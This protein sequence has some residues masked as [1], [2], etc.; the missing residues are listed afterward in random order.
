METL[1]P[2]I[3]GAIIFGAFTA[4]ALLR[5]PLERIVVGQAP[6]TD[7]PKRQIVLDV[8]L[9]FLAGI[10]GAT[11]NTIWY[12]FPVASAISLLFG[13]VVVGFFIAIDMALDRERH[14][15]LMALNSRRSL[16]LGDRLFPVTRKFFLVAVS[17]ALFVTVVIVL[18]I[19]RDI[20]WLS[21]IEQSESALIDAQ[22]S[23][24]YE[25][26]FIMAI[27]LAM[28]INLIYSY[29]KN[30]KIL[31]QN[32]TSV[33]ERVSRGDLSNL[34]PVATND[35]FGL[36]AAHTNSMIQGLRHRIRLISALKLAEEVQRNL[37]P[38]HA[39]KIPGL[40]ISGISIYCDETGGDYYDYLTFP[41]GRLGIV[42]A[43]ASD[44]GVSAALHMTTARAFLLYGTQNVDGIAGLID[45]INRHLVRDGLQTGRFVS[46]FLLEIDPKQ[47]SLRWVRAGHEPALLYE[48]GANEFKQLSGEGIVLGADGDYR[49]Q[50][51]SRHQWV[52]GSVVVIATDGVH[53]S[54]NKEDRM[55]GRERLHEIVSRHHMETAGSIQTVILKELEN[56]RGSAA[57]ED[58]VTLVVAKLL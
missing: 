23:V 44:H 14:N 55:F 24:S 34:V 56:F 28:V 1:P 17:T 30:L 3:L 6:V 32:E 15:I 53:E 27:L 7:Q 39:P 41:D 49:F 38:T 20:V 19:S 2:V 25:I 22:L 52:P 12:D 4:V 51:Y 37:L 50:A 43:D 8:S 36:I 57:Q 42:V 58:D 10:I 54:R 29:S 13:C 33:L 35:E 46:L 26:F 45:D 11:V 9:C 48:P 47:K 5:R 16:Q 31:F 21:K 40:D 18:V